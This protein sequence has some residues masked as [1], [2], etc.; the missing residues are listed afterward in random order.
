MAA[1]AQGFDRLRPRGAATRGLQDRATERCRVGSVSLAVQPG[2]TASDRLRRRRQE[3][4]D[5]AAD[6]RQ[7][8]ATAQAIGTGPLPARGREV[9][10]QET[11]AT[12]ASRAEP[13][14]VRSWICGSRSRGA[15]LTEDTGAPVTVVGILARAMAVVGIRIR[16][17][18]RHA[19]IAAAEGA[20]TEVEA[21]TTAV[22]EAA[23]SAAVAVVMRAVV[24]ATGAA[25]IANL[26]PGR[27]T[28]R[29]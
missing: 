28:K 13:V 7:G 15:R 10:V 12:E 23:T 18:A 24:E 8:V 21:A 20:L 17:M 6:S 1:E 27:I 14:R 26:L 9:T 5:S 25:A 2:A 16:V 29:L 3:I 4:R 22:V 11:M 19:A